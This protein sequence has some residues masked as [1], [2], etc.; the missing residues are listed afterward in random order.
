MTLR[1]LA[2]CPWI[3]HLTLVDNLLIQVSK[4]FALIYNIFLLAEFEFSFM[5]QFLYCFILYRKYILILCIWSCI[6]RNHRFWCYCRG[7]CVSFSTTLMWNCNIALQK[8]EKG[9]D[10]HHF[11][12]N[13]IQQLG[14][15][16]WILKLGLQ[17]DRKNMVS[18]IFLFFTLTIKI[19]TVWWLLNQASH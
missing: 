1:V 4:C 19:L 5:V 8:Q 11:V 14:E 15:A 9:K 10:L 2:E 3:Y 6:L 13:Q 12:I 18:N 7:P 16:L 17:F